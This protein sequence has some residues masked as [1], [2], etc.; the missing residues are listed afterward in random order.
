MGATP[1]RG[2]R[3]RQ[4]HAFATA[5]KHGTRTH[6]FK[7]DALSTTAPLEPLRGGSPDPPRDQ[8][9]LARSQPRLAR[10]VRRP[11]ALSGAVVL[12]A[13]TRGPWHLTLRPVTRRKRKRGSLG[14]PPRRAL[15]ISAFAVISRPAP[16]RR[17]T[18]C[19][20]TIRLRGSWWPSRSWGRTR[21]LCPHGRPP[22]RACCSR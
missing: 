7:V 18:A 12:V 9:A 2:V 14:R 6:T 21:V 17:G 13:A 3:P 8:T 1:R 16:S 22:G 19:G 20:C 10:R 4:E 5:R 11:A 15:Q